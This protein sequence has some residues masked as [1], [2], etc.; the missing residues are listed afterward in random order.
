MCDVMQKMTGSA[1][2]TFRGNQAPVIQAIQR[3]D[4]PIVAA[5]PTGGGKSMCFML[6]AF[7]VGG[8]TALSVEPLCSNKVV[9]I[10]P[11]KACQIQASETGCLV[12]IAGGVPRCLAAIC[13][14]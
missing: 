1:N 8:L 6:P 9:I 2:I 5:I 12:C 4:S 13:D 7:A 3:G 14:Y 11:T 10:K